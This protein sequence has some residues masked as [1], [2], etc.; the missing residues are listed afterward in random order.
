MLFSN[1]RELVGYRSGIRMMKLKNQFMLENYQALE[2]LFTHI[3]Q[4][5]HEMCH[6]LFA[7]KEL[8]S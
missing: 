3:A 2:S 7:I 8:C 5:K 1:T 4:M 6:H